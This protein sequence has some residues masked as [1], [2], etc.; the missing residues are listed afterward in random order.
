M[1]TEVSL[2]HAVWR[3][4]VKIEHFYD[5][6]VLAHN[7]IVKCPMDRT[8]WIRRLWLKG[9]NRT[10]E[11]VH[12]RDWY[13]VER[14]IETQRTAESAEITKGFD[15]RRLSGAQHRI[16]KNKPSGNGDILGSEVG[17]SIGSGVTN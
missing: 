6:F 9:Y 7:G 13:A 17:D 10:P 2:V 1:N 5:G 3:L 15:I 14:E 12:L 8:V 4:P 11:G 16:R